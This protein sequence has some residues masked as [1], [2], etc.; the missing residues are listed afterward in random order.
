MFS[1]NKDFCYFALIAYE[2]EKEAKTALD[3]FNNM[4][5]YS[6][7]IMVEQCCEIGK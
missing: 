4:S 7:R 5:L 1:V 6:T 3:Y 2:T